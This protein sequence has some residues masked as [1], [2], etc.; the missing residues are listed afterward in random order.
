L[1]DSTLIEAFCK[2][3]GK[4]FDNLFK[5]HRQFVASICIKYLKEKESSQDACME[6]FTKLWQN[7]CAQKIDSFRPWL[8]VFTRNHCL[9]QLR[10]EK[11][12]KILT[13][14]VELSLSV[15]PFEEDQ[16]ELLLQKMETFMHQLTTEQQTSLRMFFLEGLSYAG[17]AQSQ[18]W[19]I[20]KVKSHIQNGK[21][22]L[23]QLMKTHA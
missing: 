2:G 9:M 11:A 17:I 12:K 15:H 10:K 16:L 21:R 22:M 23:L 20:G 14:D 4:A 6:V 8:Y 13:E 18:G 19:E 5:Q 7:I 1:E 3:S